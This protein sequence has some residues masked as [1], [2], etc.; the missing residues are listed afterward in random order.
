LI[1]PASFRRALLAWYDR[2]KRDL[3]WRSASA[4]FYTVWISEIMLQQ[5]RVEAVV[6]YYQRFLARFPDMQSLARATEP[7][8]L[9]AWSGLGYYSRARSLHRAAKQIAAAG[10]PA[11]YEGLHELP[12]IGPYTA[13]AIAS[14]AAG[15]A[16][17]R[18]WMATSFA[19]L[20]G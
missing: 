15:P 6:P 4:D 14:I 1:R 19:W 16:A 10:A 8:V 12:G 11:G 13:A 2:S 18:G 3:P 5:T 20:A 17:C 7:E 9:T